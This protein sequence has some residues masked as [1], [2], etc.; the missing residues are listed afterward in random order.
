MGPF[1]LGVMT[2][3]SSRST[4]GQN[5]NGRG[6][7]GLGFGS[8]SK[9]EGRDSGFS[10]QSSSATSFVGGLAVAAA[11]FAAPLSANALPRGLEV[12]GGDIQTSSPTAPLG[13]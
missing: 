11:S 2:K 4:K 13:H 6:K 9:M 5:N 7:S 1:F 8:N 3:R 12:R 10:K